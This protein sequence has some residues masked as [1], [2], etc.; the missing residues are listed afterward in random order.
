MRMIHPIKQGRHGE[1]GGLT[2]VV[3][4][5]LVVLMSLAAFGMSR[6]AIRQLASSGN[7]LQGGKADEASNAGLDWFVVWSAADN[8]NAAIGTDNETSANWKLQRAIGDM[9]LYIS[10][11]P[12]TNSAYQHLKDDGLLASSDSTRTWDVAAAVT[13]DESQATSSDLV[14]DNGASTVLQ[15][16]NNTG[17][18]V[19]QSF[20]LSTIRYLGTDRASLSTQSNTG[21]TIG[22]LYFQVQSLGK[23]AVPIGNGSYLRYQQRREMIAWAPPF[24]R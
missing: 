9:T 14:F 8:Q 20:D 13:S 21:V 7:I 24:Q 17:N 6:N 16:K 19:V 23:A 22:H 1:Q 3:A 5:V 2:I 18:P 4:L 10:P 12:D 15:A 11:Y